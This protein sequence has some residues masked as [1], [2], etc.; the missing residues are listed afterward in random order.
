MDPYK[1]RAFV[2]VGAGR[3][4]RFDT[5]TVNNVKT[6]LMRLGLQIVL[7][8]DADYVIIPD[9]ARP[10]ANTSAVPISYSTIIDLLARYP[11]PAPTKPSDQIRQPR[12]Q[13]IMSA[14]TSRAWQDELARVRKILGSR[15]STKV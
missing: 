9:G 11:R 7:R 4:H 2:S 15:P 14:D 8:H 5:G 13:V 1:I 3:T 6:E 12:P 10:P